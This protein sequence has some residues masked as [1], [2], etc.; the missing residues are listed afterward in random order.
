MQVLF[1]KMLML[2]KMT[3]LLS[4]Y[5]AYSKVCSDVIESDTLQFASVN[6]NTRH[7]KNALI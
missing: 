6:L 1:V 5:S 2:W 3:I 7:R 4:K